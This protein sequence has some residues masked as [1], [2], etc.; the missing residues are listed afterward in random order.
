MCSATAGPLPGEN[1]PRVGLRTGYTLSGRTDLFVVKDDGSAERSASARR[2]TTAPVAAL[3]REMAATLRF[4]AEPK[5]ATLH[6]TRGAAP[7]YL[8]RGT[9][10]SG[11]IAELVVGAGDVSAQLTGGR[12]GR[13]A[14]PALSR[15][16]H[17]APDV[18]TLTCQVATQ[19]AQ[20][21]SYKTGSSARQ[22]V[23]VGNALGVT[24]AAEPSASY[25][26]KPVA[27]RRPD[28]IVLG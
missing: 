16:L 8:H 6:R 24:A 14:S 9:V 4:D 15:S 27:G 22:G 7:A 5:N 17:E 21:Y 12:R 18:F 10:S 3:S 13:A 11:S 1:S 2:M 26:R 20:S 23:G 25:G 19:R 28:S